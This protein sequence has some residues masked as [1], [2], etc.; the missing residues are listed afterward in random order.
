MFIEVLLRE[1]RK[2]EVVNSISIMEIF[3]KD[4]SRKEN[5]MARDY[6]YGP[7]GL[8]MMEV[9][10]MVFFVV[11]V[12]GNQKMM[13]HMKGNTET[14]KRMEKEHTHGTTE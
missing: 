3:T 4:S 14:T 13:T 5:L 1:G 9:S 11:M 10:R 12:N 2:M 8:S 6:I 7:M